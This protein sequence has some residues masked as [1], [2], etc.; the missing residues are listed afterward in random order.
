MDCI[1]I[2]DDKLSRIVLEEFIDKT[3]DL[4]LRASFASSIDASNY[5]SN[6]NRTD[7]LFL[8]IEMPEMNGIDLLDSLK[9]IPQVI[10]TSSRE[11]YALQAFDFDVTDYLLK[12]ITLSRFFK[13]VN[14]AK[15]RHISSSFHA[16]SSN[17]IFIK[18]GSSLVKM[19][20]EDVLWVEALE[21]Y[22]VLNTRNE[23]YTLHFTMK[24]IQKKLPNSQF[25]R[26]HR[27]YIINIRNIS[28]IR[29]NSVEIK[30]DDQIQSLPIGK[31]YKENLLRDINLISK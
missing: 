6:G 7:L 29:D 11:K 25:I 21:N 20:L 5:L 24:A 1:V 10:I 3:K 14:K 28:V 12:P 31:S 2:D 16:G 17:E 18:K 30:F 27:S 23:K 8:D 15:E 19:K 13:A 22:I 4:Q 26:I 9:I